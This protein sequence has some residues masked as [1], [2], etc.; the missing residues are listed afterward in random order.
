M[1]V[2]EVRERGGRSDRVDLV[3]G[4]IVERHMHEGIVLQSQDDVAHVV[5]PILRELVEDGFDPPLVLVGVLDRPHRVACHQPFVHRELLSAV[6]SE[7]E[8]G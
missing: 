4:V 5:G 7:T 3:V 6:A 1:T 8:A 2:L